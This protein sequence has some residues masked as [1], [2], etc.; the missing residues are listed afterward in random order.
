M[1]KLVFMNRIDFVMN[2]CGHC[3]EMCL[4]LI[5][6]LLILLVYL[7]NFMNIYNYF[8]NYNGYNHKNFMKICGYIMNQKLIL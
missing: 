5:D 6:L 8:I 4:L 1:V 7:V 2:F 3:Y